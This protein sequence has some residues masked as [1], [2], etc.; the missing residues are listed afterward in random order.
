MGKIGKTYAGAGGCV[1]A[2]RR[3]AVQLL[4]RPLADTRERAMR[5]QITAAVGWLICVLAL[6]GWAFTLKSS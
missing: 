3:P 2:N 5:H 4:E 6:I 1:L